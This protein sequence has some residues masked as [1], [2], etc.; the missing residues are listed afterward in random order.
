MTMFLIG[1]ILCFGALA[2]VLIAYILHSREK[3]KEINEEI[4][5]QNEKAVEVYNDEKKNNEEIINSITPDNICDKLQDL[6]EKGQQRRRIKK[7]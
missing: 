7:N 6:S 2:F 1:L 3:E 4:K 5:K